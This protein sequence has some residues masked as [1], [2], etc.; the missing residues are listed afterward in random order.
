MLTVGLILF[1]FFGFG[2]FCGRDRFFG[3]SGFFEFAGFSRFFEF[4][5]FSGF[6]CFLFLFF[7]FFT[8]LNRICQSTTLNS[9]R[10]R[11]I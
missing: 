5:G 6:F 4:A 7:K 1:G 8:M 10:C 3:F 11:T 2:N 9:N